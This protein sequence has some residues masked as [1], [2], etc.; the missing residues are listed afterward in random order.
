MPDDV[1]V[2]APL[3][4]RWLA[5]AALLAVAVLVR[6]SVMFYGSLSGDDA[7]VALVAKHVQYSTGGLEDGVSLILAPVVAAGEGFGS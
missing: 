7:I 3:R 2:E 5:V 6:V 1:H 4:T